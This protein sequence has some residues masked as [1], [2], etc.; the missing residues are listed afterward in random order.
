MNKTTKILISALALICTLGSVVQTSLANNHKDTTFDFEMYGDGADNAYNDTRKKED[1]TATYVK[2]NS[3]SDDAYV[4]VCGTNHSNLRNEP[5]HHE[6]GDAGRINAG[7]YRYISNTV[8][9]TYKYAYLCFGRD[10]RRMNHF[11]GK[12]SPDNISGRY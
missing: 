3:N 2:L 11:I 9:P 8:Y 12:W 6:C 5:Y 7:S 10:N 4:V 1:N